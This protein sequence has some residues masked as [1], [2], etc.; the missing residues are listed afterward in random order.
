LGGL[1]REPA[2]A[3][4]EAVS[5]RP[6][7]SPTGGPRA[8]GLLWLQ[9]AV[10]NQVTGGLLQSVAGE[11]PLLFGAGGS[12]A[13]ARSAP[14]AGDTGDVLHQSIAPSWAGA[15]TDAALRRQLAT[16]RRATVDAEDDA[17]RETALD[18]LPVLELEAARRKPSGTSPL[19]AQWPTTGGMP[20]ALVD[21]AGSG[22]GVEDSG[23]S[24]V[25]TDTS[26]SNDLYDQ[27]PPESSGP[28]DAGVRAPPHD[29]GWTATG[30]REDVGGVWIRPAAG[31]DQEPVFYTHDE[32]MHGL[33]GWIS[34]KL[35]WIPFL[36]TVK[37]IDEA[38][39]GEQWLSGDELST[40]ERIFSG[41]VG[42]VGAVFDLSAVTGL[43]RG[44]TAAVR[45]TERELAEGELEAA[46]AAGRGD[47]GGA[48]ARERQGGLLGGG[49]G[50]ASVYDEAFA[51]N[52]V[53]R[54]DDTVKPKHGRFSRRV[55][56]VDVSPEPKNGQRALENSVPLNEGRRVGVDVDNQEIVVL[57]R[58]GNLVK[59][60]KVVGG[61][62]HGHVRKWDTLSPDMRKALTREG[63]TVDKKGKIT[64]PEGWKED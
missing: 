19:L 31:V 5:R 26:S 29:A 32:I 1:E 4:P 53:Y 30:E 22:S 45:T 59:D 47:L 38:V 55:G 7:V 6:D 52:R 64:I 44:E 23:D 13:A 50:A 20:A 41:V 37:S 63:V 25:R 8:G 57:D 28:P 60:K 10:G 36:G 12:P 61:Q 3:P 46:S 11:A 51:E 9:Q 42:T 43:A 27:G 2:K 34:D 48:T 24:A 40:G 15:L 18:N 14:A 21:W 62:Y 49:P 56:G 39:T 33:R 35:N 17:I 54:V 16:V 58:T